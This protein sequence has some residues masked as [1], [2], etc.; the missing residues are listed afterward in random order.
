M[1]IS[2]FSVDKFKEEYEKYCKGYTYDPVILPECKRIVVFGDIHGDYDLAIELLLISKV[3]KIIGKNKFEWIGGDTVVVQIGDQIH[4]YRPSKNEV[5]D[6]DKDQASDLKILKLFTDIAELARKK[7]GYVY[8]L[9]GNHE[10]Q[11]ILGFFQ[12]VSKKN[13]YEMQKIYKPSVES[14]IS[15][16][17]NSDFYSVED[18]LSENINSNRYDI[19]DGRAIFKNP[20]DALREAFKS[21]NKYGKF[22]GCTRYAC[23]IIGSFVFVHAGIINKTLDD[24]N[25]KSREDIELIDA[26]FKAWML[27]LLSKKDVDDIITQRFDKDEKNSSLFWT[28]V[29]GRIEP[30]KSMDY[31]ECKNNISKVLGILKVGNIVVGHTPQSF[32]NNDSINGTCDNAVIRV[33]NG[34]SHAFNLFD[35]K[36]LEKNSK[37]KHRRTQ[38][39]E[40]LSNKFIYVCDK[41][42]KVALN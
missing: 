20:L 14:G 39:L 18:H 7:G 19:E 41:D 11:N 16:T 32:I 3:I 38:Y 29:L 37:T 42:N 40:I 35:K 22:L 12:N 34:S 33:D 4:N 31:D 36:Y 24:L 10:N 25:I 13:I 5:Y 30:N 27:G 17:S 28:R 15:E 1:D 23:V 8:S 6:E 26:K 9:S 2:N 21:G